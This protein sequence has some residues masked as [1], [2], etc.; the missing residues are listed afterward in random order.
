MMGSVKRVLVTGAAGTVGS[1]IVGH[2]LK[3]GYGIVVTDLS[4]EE[5]DMHTDFW[6]KCAIQCTYDI[7]PSRFGMIKTG[8]LKNPAFV[9]SLFDRENIDAVIHAA[10]LI[11]VALPYEKLKA[12]NVDAPVNLYRALAKSYGKVFVF[13]SSGS[14]YGSAPVL[15]ENTDIN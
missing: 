15:T 2:L 5:M 6:C 12:A 10:A 4:L 1:F 11:D 8:D 9:K 14:I 13:I 7:V 3:K